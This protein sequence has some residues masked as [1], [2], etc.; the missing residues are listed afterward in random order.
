MSWRRAAVGLLLLS[1]ILPSCDRVDHVFFAVHRLGNKVE[2]L[3][4]ACSGSKPPRLSD[5]RVV[6]FHPTARHQRRVLLWR[7]VPAEGRTAPLSSAVV[8]K[9]PPGFV[10]KTALAGRHFGPWLRVDVRTHSSHLTGAGPFDLRLP[11]NHRRVRTSSGITIPRR[12]FTA[13]ARDRCDHRPAWLAA[14]VIVGLFVAPAGA[15]LA[16]GLFIWT[17]RRRRLGSE[18]DA[19]GSE[20]PAGTE[21]EQP[22]RGPPPP[23]PPA[24]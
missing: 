8:G 21:G 24:V 11:Y 7:I 22:P 5:V 4:N 9:A 13:W 16:G 12:D 17:V 10:E 1:T 15:A 6:S 23:P 18:S 2:L 19:T 3:F 14:G 20:P